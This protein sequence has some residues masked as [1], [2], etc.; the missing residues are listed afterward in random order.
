MTVE[1]NF[2]RLFLTTFLR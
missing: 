2:F 1:R